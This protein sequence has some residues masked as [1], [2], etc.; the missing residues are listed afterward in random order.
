MLTTVFI[1]TNFLSGIYSVLVL[2]FIT[3]IYTYNQQVSHSIFLHAVPEKTKVSSKDIKLFENKVKL[4]GGYYTL[5]LN[6]FILLLS[7]GFYDLYDYFCY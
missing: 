4:L 3:S 6:H 5:D 1:L 7:F 2:R